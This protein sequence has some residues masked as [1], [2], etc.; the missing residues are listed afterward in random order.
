[1]LKHK[2]KK[3]TNGPT[4]TVVYTDEDTN[5]VHER[6]VNAVFTDGEYDRVA[7]LERVKEVGRGVSQKI[8]SGVITT[9]EVLPIVEP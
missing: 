5:I 9:Q 6:T 7:T 3:Y 1:M 8:A 2:I 4:V